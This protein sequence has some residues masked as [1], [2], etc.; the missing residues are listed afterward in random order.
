M[1]ALQEYGRLIKTIHIVRCLDSPEYRRSIGANSTRV[2]NSTICAALFFANEGE[3]RR[4]QHED[5]TTRVLCLNLAANAIIAWNTVYMTEALDVLRA[6]GFAVDDDDLTHVPPTLWSH[7]N[8][9][10]KYEF[11]VE[12]GARRAGLR[13]LR[14]PITA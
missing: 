10:G 13:P 6:E 11:D 1:R 5:Q 7:V 3:I 4:S 8:I 2:N 9:Y 14:Q 12:A